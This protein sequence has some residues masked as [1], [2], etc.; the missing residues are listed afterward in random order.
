MAH[1]CRSNVRQAL[2]QS[3]KTY[4]PR[5]LSKEYHLGYFFPGGSFSSILVG[6]ILWITHSSSSYCYFMRIGFS[7]FLPHQGPL[8]NGVKD[9]RIALQKLVN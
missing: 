4:F 3:C 5:V 2:T 1:F 7:R 8:M 9:S 6:L